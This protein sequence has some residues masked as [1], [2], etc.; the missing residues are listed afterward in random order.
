MSSTIVISLAAWWGL[1]AAFVAIRLY[2][3]ADHA[4][5]SGRDF[6]GYPRLVS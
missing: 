5:R 6:V 4:S 3:T 2:A 1:N